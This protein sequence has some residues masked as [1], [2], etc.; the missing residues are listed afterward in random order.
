[1]SHLVGELIGASLVEEVGRGPSSGGKAPIMLSVRADARHVIGLDLGEEFFNAAV[2]DLRGAVLHSLRAPLDGRS[3]SA[4]LAL[5]FELVDALIAS[6]GSR[7]LLGIG[8]GA[9]GLI[10]SRAGVAR[11][12][13]NLEWEELAVGPIVAERYGVPVV[14]ANDSQA[15][16]LGE[17]T[18]VE[19]S[20]RANLVVIRVGRGLGAGII[21]G[22]QL[23][24]GDGSGAG[25][26]GHTTSVIDGDACRCG[27]VGCLETVAS[28]GA[29]VRAAERVDPGV[30]DDRALVAAFLAGDPAIERIVVEAGHRLGVAVGTLIGALNIARI[31]LVGPAAALGD[32]WLAAV[33][34]KASV[35]SLAVLARETH[36]EL[37]DSGDDGVV[38]GA[39]ALLMARELGLSADR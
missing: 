34:E 13:V 25:E 7:P 33:R 36:I 12:T 23:F 22:G 5:V 10:D 24:Q 39:S 30:S 37:G 6:N 26:I 38:R 15:A 20:R 3:G 35:T 17:L 14:V 9:P 19:G 18:F 4:A 16:A 31:V 32:E 8:I 27:R 1:M 29:M 11:R 21:V 28:M 2:V